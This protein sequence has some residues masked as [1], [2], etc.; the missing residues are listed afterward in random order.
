LKKRKK[1]VPKP[2]ELRER[3]QLNVGAKQ[4]L[5]PFFGATRPLLHPRVCLVYNGQHVPA[6]HSWI[7]LLRSLPQF[8]FLLEY[9]SE[10]EGH[11]GILMLTSVAMPQVPELRGFYLGCGFNSAGIM[12]AGML[13]CP[14]LPFRIVYCVCDREYFKAQKAS[15]VAMH[16]FDTHSPIRFP[17]VPHAQNLSTL[18]SAFA[19]FLS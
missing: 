1:E 6:R 13:A 3:A 12:L 10:A 17:V 5:G 14:F 9:T 18:F 19:L 4:W 8:R 7:S 16:A 11:S 2:A 15:G